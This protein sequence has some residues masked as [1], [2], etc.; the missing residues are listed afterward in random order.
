MLNKLLTK[1]RWFMKTRYR[2]LYFASIGP[3]QACIA[4]YAF[5][6]AFYS[7][8]TRRRQLHKLIRSYFGAGQVL[9]YASGRG[10]ISAFLSA[11]GVGPKSS[12]LLS[13]FT[14]LAFPTAVL[15]AG[16]KT[17]SIDVNNIRGLSFWL[18]K[19]K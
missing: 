1:A 7:R 2:S 15:A 6:T 8:D 19:K 13:S 12:V 18:P 14:C 16:S 3:K 5:A 10:S 11:A 17:I 9:A 4:L